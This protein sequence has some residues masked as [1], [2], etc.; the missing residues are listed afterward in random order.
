MAI[1]I[2]SITSHN[3]YQVNEMIPSYFYTILALLFNYDAE[4]DVIIQENILLTHNY[5][6]HLSF[7]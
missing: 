2:E 6:C 1:F 3:K 7:K 5:T 4:T